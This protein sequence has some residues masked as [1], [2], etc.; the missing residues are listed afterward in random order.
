MKINFKGLLVAC[1]MLIGLFG[2]WMDKG[3]N[4]YGVKNKETGFGELIY[5]R[6]LLLSPFYAIMIEDGIIVKIMMF[7]SAG[8]TFGG[9]LILI[10][11]ILTIFKLKINWINLVIFFVATFG[12]LLFFLSLGANIGVGITITFRWGLKL[13]LLGLGLMFVT[14]TIQILKDI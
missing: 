10:A 12:I 4:P 13:M 8:T 2:P 1:F 3:L 6:R 11:S 14:T 9:I 5:H 7:L